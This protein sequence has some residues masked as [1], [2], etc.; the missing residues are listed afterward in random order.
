MSVGKNIMSAVQVVSAMP[1]RTLL[2]MLPMVAGTA[3][4][5]A[6]LAIE[7]GVSK[8][9]NEAA[10][11]FGLDQ[12]TV[13]SGSAITANQSATGKVTEK[14]VAAIR[15]GLGKSAKDVIGV[16]RD[17]FPVSFGSESKTYTIFGVTPSWA[18]VRN[19]PAEKPGKF[20]DQDDCDNSRAVCII[21]KMVKR[22]LFGDKDP[23]GQEVIINQVPFT[24]QG[25]LVTRGASPA[26]GDRDARV[27]TPITA[28]R[29]RLK[30]VENIDQIVTL[31]AS[32]EP[33]LLADVHKQMSAILRKQHNIAADQPEDVTI[34][35]P[36]II[37]ETSRGMSH[38]LFWMLIGLAAICGVVAAVIILLVAGQAIR[39]RRREIGIR[40]AVGATPGDI[41]QLIW[42]ECLIVSVLGGVIGVVVGLAGG[43]GVVQWLNVG[44]QPQ[45][46]LGFAFNPVDLLGPLALVAI[47]SLAGLLP[48]QT[49][50]GIDP[51]RALQPS[52]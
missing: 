12:V 35:T 21:G 43:W 10:E 30:N 8:L 37:A 41:M 1:G 46:L 45:N 51:A 32:R 38:Q 20:I 49:A 3:L 52:G 48:A 24:V 28:F 14:D 27:I 33:Q 13:R 36:Q 7:S 23:V 42:T 50:T 22:E 26:E 25:V 15:E 2:L 4:A 40:R 44:R 17:K 18:E 39:A 29:H 6:T 34:R 5:M 47:G 31:A 11:S 19:F 9:A 16:R